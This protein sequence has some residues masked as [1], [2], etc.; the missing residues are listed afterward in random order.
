M[1]SLLA[2]ESHIKA[3]TQNYVHASINKQHMLYI[4]LHYLIIVCLR[5]KRD[6]NYAFQ[7]SFVLIWNYY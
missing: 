6:S 1:E 4:I 3:A 2:K 5:K 7:H